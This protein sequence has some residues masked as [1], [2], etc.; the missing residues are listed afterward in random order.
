[1][2][3]SAGLSG[4]DLSQEALE[5]TTVSAEI[6]LRGAGFDIDDEIQGA[7]IELEG[8][9]L[10]AVNLSRPSFQSVSDVRFS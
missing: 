8:R 7:L 9:P 4:R 5:I 10:S 2:I 3:L 6:G 1:M